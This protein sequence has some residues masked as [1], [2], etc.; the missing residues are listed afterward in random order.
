M[1]YIQHVLEY[2]RVLGEQ[3]FHRRRRAWL[4]GDILEQPN[5]A[6]VRNLRI[7]P[8]R[9]HMA[10]QGLTLPIDIG[11]IA[12]K[13][14]SRIQRTVGFRTDQEIALRYQRSF[15]GDP[16]AGPDLTNPPGSVITK[17]LPVA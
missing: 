5:A 17:R 3:T 14:T 2:H 15:C 12:I 9:R 6:L 1:P 11:K 13:S 10:A 16:S 4:L 8:T 7:G